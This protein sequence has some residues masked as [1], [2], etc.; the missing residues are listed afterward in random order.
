MK[1]YAFHNHKLNQNSKTKYIAKYIF[2]YKYLVFDMLSICI[3]LCIVFFLINLYHVICL[4]FQEFIPAPNIYNPKM[5]SVR[6]KGPQV[7]FQG[8]TKFGRIDN[9]YPAPNKYTIKPA[10]QRAKPITQK[11]FAP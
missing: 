2:R 9:C 5:D 8:R 3:D 10:I 6:P 7:S 11:V 1:E 4:H